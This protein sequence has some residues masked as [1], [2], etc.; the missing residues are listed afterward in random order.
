M[1]TTYGRPAASHTPYA[2]QSHHHFPPQPQMGLV[3]GHSSSLPR[4]IQEPPAVGTRQRTPFGF[5]GGPHGTTP[6]AGPIMGSHRGSGHTNGVSVGVPFANASDDGEGAEDCAALLFPHKPPFAGPNSKKTQPSLLPPAAPPLL[7]S[8]VGCTPNSSRESTEEKV[9]SG[10]NVEKEDTHRSTIAFAL[11]K[12]RLLA[13]ARAEANSKAMVGRLARIVA[14]E[15]ASRA[16]EDAA[17]EKEK[18]RALRKEASDAKKKNSIP[19]NN[20]IFADD[21][22]DDDLSLL[23]IRPKKTAAATRGKGGG[24]K[25]ASLSPSPRLA[26]APQ[27]ERMAEAGDAARKRRR[28]TFAPSPTLI[29]CTPMSPQ[30]LNMT[31]RCCACGVDDAGKCPSDS[32]TAAPSDLLSPQQ[33]DAPASTAGLSNVVVTATP[34]TTPDNAPADSS[35]CCSPRGSVLLA[36]G[37]VADAVIN[38]PFLAT[39]PN[40]KETASA[41][42]TNNGVQTAASQIVSRDVCT[43]GGQSA[44]AAESPTS[45]RRRTEQL[46]DELTM[47]TPSAG[48]PCLVCSSRSPVGAAAVPRRLRSPPPPMTLCVENFCGAFS[49]LDDSSAPLAACSAD[50]QDTDEGAS[51]VLLFVILEAATIAAVNN[52]TT[53]KPTQQLSLSSYLGKSSV[54]MRIVASADCQSPT[55][56]S[57]EVARGDILSVTFVC[58]AYAEHNCCEGG[59]PLLPANATS[60]RRLLLSPTRA[61]PT[62]CLSSAMGKIV[63]S[64][65]TDL[66]G[67]P[68]TKDANGSAASPSRLGGGLL[69]RQSPTSTSQQNPLLR[70]SGGAH[71]D[72]DLVGGAAVVDQW[73]SP[74]PS[75][76][77][78]RVSFV[79]DDL[80]IVTIVPA[81]PNALSSLRAKPPFS[82]VGLDGR[83]DDDDAMPSSLGAASTQAAGG[84]GSFFSFSQEEEDDDTVENA[85]APTPSSATT[86]LNAS[87]ANIA[88]NSQN[89]QTVDTAGTFASGSSP[90][91]GTTFAAPTSPFAS[92]YAMLC[93]PPQFSQSSPLI[94]NKQRQAVPF[95]WAAAPVTAHGAQ[96]VDRFIRIGAEKTLT[97][98]SPPLTPL[99]GGAPAPQRPNIF[100]KQAAPQ[101]RQLS[102]QSPIAAVRGPLA[103]RLTVGHPVA[104][105][106]NG[107]P[108]PSSP[109]PSAFSAAAH[110]RS[111]PRSAALRGAFGGANNYGVGGGTPLLHQ[112][113]N[114]PLQVPLCA[115]GHNGFGT[116]AL[117]AIMGRLGTIG[118]RNQRAASS[119][120]PLLTPSAS[121]VEGGGVVPSPTTACATTT[122]IP[123]AA[124]V[125]ACGTSEE[126][127]DAPAV[128]DERTRAEENDVQQPDALHSINANS[129]GNIAKEAISGDQ[130]PPRAVA[131]SSDAVT[132]ASDGILLMPQEGAPTDAC[133]PPATSAPAGSDTVMASD[134]QVMESVVR[135]SQK[136]GTLLSP[137]PAVSGEEDKADLAC[138]SSVAKGSNPQQESPLGS[139][140]A[141]NPLQP[142]ETA[143]TEKILEGET[144]ASTTSVEK[145]AKLPARK[146]TKPAPKPKAAKK[147][148]T[149]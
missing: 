111:M 69:Q 27:L 51:D 106:N 75:S 110:I 6:F 109:S 67:I 143:A 145:H 147:R 34:R 41:A 58:G 116:A 31:K 83:A 97:S 42:T 45:K 135:D 100:L 85:A 86:A 44:S 12:R 4:R 140:L 119:N 26:L 136:N 38:S 124:A 148:R 113:P 76:S 81:A 32:A 8:S 63:P 19:S 117:E 102:P 15:A 138:F 7:P 9:T 46:P 59:S 18:K 54:H 149:A 56:N 130:S 126:L 11:H 95:G 137:A 57:S 132:I 72:S 48:V 88:A 77:R 115:P 36:L 93:T 24:M 43:C 114:S 146:T 80:E 91:A 133:S 98:P 104:F 49:L 28:V 129:D 10:G 94:F 5:F 125:I 20:N 68:P 21:D 25:P 122:T 103:G 101:Q 66:G 112:P 13:L 89:A 90:A 142:R 105:A 127:C 70:L 92:E 35:T 37:T 1:F 96:S 30:Q 79:L 64:D 29:T 118:G 61:L 99:G 60:L 84:G 39:A 47:P 3:H 52:R 17:A 141:D 108:H 128:A 123:T 33:R 78:R 144:K 22:A 40:T 50:C 121:N 23:C 2:Q 107:M 65:V 55:N 62:E 16:L 71:A 134:P 131:V 120:S 87:L 14:F 53:S 82:T 73:P 139:P 74:R